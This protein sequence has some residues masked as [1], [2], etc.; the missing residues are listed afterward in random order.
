MK[1]E[2]IHFCV[3]DQGRI[4][5]LFVLPLTSLKQTKT[6]GPQQYITFG[7]IPSWKSVHLMV[8]ATGLCDPPDALNSQRHCE[9]LGKRRA[10]RTQKRHL[11]CQNDPVHASGLGQRRIQLLT[12]KGG[13]KWVCTSEQEFFAKRQC[14]EMAALLSLFL[15]ERVH[16][17]SVL[18][19]EC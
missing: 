6:T 8:W 11:I 16:F 4:C 13:G 12:M 1:R 17:L 3:E 19:R 2:E 7:H 18:S 14:E 15:R 5:A 9:R 10:Y